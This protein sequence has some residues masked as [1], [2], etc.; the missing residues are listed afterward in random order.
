MGEPCSKSCCMALTDN[1]FIGLPL[2]EI[3]DLQALY[4]QVLRDI[5]KTGRSYAFPGLS[6]T[7][8]DITEI[9]NMLS[10]LRMAIDF[11][12]GGS[13]AIKQFANVTINTQ[14]QFDP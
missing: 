10:L 2:V 3:Q 14:Q 9:T 8:A 5:A 4:L 1:P 13:G 7:R 11:T 12:A 6:L